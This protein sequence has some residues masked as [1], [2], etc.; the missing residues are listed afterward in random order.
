MTTKI[1]VLLFGILL[2]PG[3]SFAQ[4]INYKG[5]A[6]KV[7]GSWKLVSVEA[8][9]PN[10]DI[11]RD[12]GQ[13]P[14]GFLAYD[15]NGNVTVQFMRDPR[16]IAVSGILTSDETKAAFDGYYAYFGNY[17]IDEKAGVVTHYIKG[18]LRPYEVGSVYKRLFELSGDKLKLSTP[19]MPSAAA[20]SGG[21]SR[22]YKLTW[23]C[24]K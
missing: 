24:V 19:P 22:I 16:P 2:L 23:E 4:K 15:R 20:G 6:G 5:I 10:G 12:W 8:T 18:S 9:R 11:I 14:T 21:E 13:T 7:V 17:Q 3:V 1:L